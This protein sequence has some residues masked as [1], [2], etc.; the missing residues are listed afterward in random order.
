[1]RSVRSG[2][3]DEE[4]ECG[5]VG[6]EIWSACVFVGGV[7]RLKDLPSCVRRFGV[8]GSPNAPGS[9]RSSAAELRAI[10]VSRELLFN[11]PRRPAKRQASSH[12]FAELASR[13]YLGSSNLIPNSKR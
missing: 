10:L 4:A 12:T 11:V 13:P 8:K 5:C 9:R 6:A 7:E 1:M 3:E 2:A